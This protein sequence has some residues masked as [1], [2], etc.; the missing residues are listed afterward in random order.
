MFYPQI[1]LELVHQTDEPNR[2][3]INQQLLNLCNDRAQHII[4]S[5]LQENRTDILMVATVSHQ[6][7][8]EPHPRYKISFVFATSDTATRAYSYIFI[9]RKPESDKFNPFS[10]MHRHNGGYIKHFYLYTPPL[11]PFQNLLN[12]DQGQLTSK[13]SLL[14]HLPEEETPSFWDHEANMNM[15]S[16]EL[17]GTYVNW[18]L[19]APAAQNGNLYVVSKEGQ[20]RLD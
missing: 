18:L 1:Y 11:A 10:K 7:K 17:L 3:E 20:G 2:G 19:T 15:F 14:Y 13:A 12:K 5:C 4:Q 8:H 9:T 6:L 16:E